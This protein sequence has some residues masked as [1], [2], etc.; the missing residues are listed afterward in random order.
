M[1]LLMVDQYGDLGG[2]QRCFLEAAEG[3]RARNW[4]VYAAVPS[5]GP[6]RGELTRRGVETAPLACGP[7]TATRKSP[8]DMLRFAGQFPSQVA[9]LRGI[10]RRDEIDA[11]YVNGS[12]VLPAVALARCGRPVVF[13]V[14]WVVTQPLALKLSHWALHRSEGLVIATSKFVARSLRQVVA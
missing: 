8:V 13:H 6:L 12:Q 9:G 2:G 14:H 5:A 10:I 3:F 4:K 7:F 11:M 1:R